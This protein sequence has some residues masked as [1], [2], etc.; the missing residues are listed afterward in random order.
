VNLLESPKSTANHL[1]MGPDGVVYVPRTGT[2]AEF[3]PTNDL[4]RATESPRSMEFTRDAI[5]DSGQGSGC[6]TYSADLAGSDSG[7]GS[8]CL[9]YSADLAGSDSGQ[10][11]GCLTY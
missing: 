3:Q 4:Y 8:G 10:G 9:T 6:L 11:S 2:V 1:M 5:D 7:Q